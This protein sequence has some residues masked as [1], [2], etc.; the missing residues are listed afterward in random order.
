MAV[1]EAL[2]EAADEERIAT[3]R[4]YEW[5]EA[6]LSLGYFQPAADRRQHPA[7]LECP[8]VRRSSGGGAILHDRELTYS[9][10]MP[11]ERQS[12]AHA[13][14]LSLS[15]HE[16][17]TAALA[18]LGISARL[19]QATGPRSAEQPF[20]CFA[21]RAVGDLLVSDCK[22][23]GSAQRRRRG[24]IL[25]HGSVLLASSRFA[26]ELPGLRELTGQAV[27]AGSLAELF[28]GALADRFNLE[29]MAPVETGPIGQR[30]AT[31]LLEKFG[32]A[33]WNLRR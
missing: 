20:L 7:S 13:T 25:Q 30:T 9:F 18:M 16:A 6:T 17:L 11:M 33:S 1:D 14:R 15:I 3:L 29:W 22:I 32:A 10:A 4:F 24:A 27:F 12:A 8:L 31:L 2:L 21:R 19:C 26:G 28:Q 5:A 23:A